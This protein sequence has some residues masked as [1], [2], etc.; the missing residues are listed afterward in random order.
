MSVITLKSNVNSI[1][2]LLPDEIMD[3][4]Q[5]Y[6]KTETTCMTNVI[7]FTQ[8]HSVVTMWPVSNYVDIYGSKCVINKT[9]DDGMRFTTFKIGELVI[10]MGVSLVNE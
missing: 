7:Q 2:Q 5:S 3:I 9:I 1:A 6:A 4:I 8:N 10:F